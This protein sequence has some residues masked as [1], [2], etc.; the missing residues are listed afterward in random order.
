[1]TIDDK[2]RRSTLDFDERKISTSEHIM[3][4][5]PR[6]NAERKMQ[7]ERSRRVASCSCQEESLWLRFRLLK[8]RNR[9]DGFQDAASFVVGK[10]DLNRQGV[11][12]ATRVNSSVEFRN[13]VVKPT[14][15]LRNR[16]R[17]GPFLRW[18]VISSTLCILEW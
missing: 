14:R 1:M 7:G 10:Q 9:S 8:Y 16:D 6:N 18:V 4:L 11:V 12:M 13:L 5:N 17:F 15:E 2:D 3:V